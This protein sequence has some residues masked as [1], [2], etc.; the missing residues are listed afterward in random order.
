MFSLFNFF[1]TKEE[2]KLES[3]MKMLWLSP[4][5]D[6]VDKILEQLLEKDSNSIVIFLNQLSESL[7]TR[8]T[9]EIVKNILIKYNHSK[10]NVCMAVCKLLV[11]DTFVGAACAQ[12]IGNEKSSYN[13][14]FY[15]KIRVF[16][17]MEMG[18]WRKF[19][20]SCRN[21]MDEFQPSLKTKTIEYSCGLFNEPLNFTLKN[22]SSTNNILSLYNGRIYKN[23]IMRT[24]IEVPLDIPFSQKDFH[25]FAEH[26]GSEPLVII[27]KHIGEGI[28]VPKDFYL[29]FTE[30][31]KTFGERIYPFVEVV[32]TWNLLDTIQQ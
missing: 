21:K 26:A 30:T 9:S 31:T 6:W 15:H 23:Q 4:R 3:F 17:A 2:P 19:L 28:T 7:V 5:I 8:H 25:S 10:W 24:P 16:K 1:A 22:P 14:D 13:K 11:P 12:A 32:S 27:C 20:Q 29:V 18:V